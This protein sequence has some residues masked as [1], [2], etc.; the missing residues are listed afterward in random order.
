MTRLALGT[1]A[2]TDA[3]QVPPQLVPQLHRSLRYHQRYL[4]TRFQEIG[5]LLV[6]LHHPLG[7]SLIGTVPQSVVF[8][9][10]WAILPQRFLVGTLDSGRIVFGAEQIGVVLVLP[11]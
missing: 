6:D 11:G 9:G 8:S 1:C 3:L 2:C 5:I 10:V 4:L 7:D